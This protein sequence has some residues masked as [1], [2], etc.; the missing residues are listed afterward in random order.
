MACLASIS[1]FDN[2]DYSV[3]DTAYQLK[4]K[5]EGDPV[6]ETIRQDAN[7]FAWQVVMRPYAQWREKHKI[8]AAIAGCE[9]SSN[10]IVKF[11]N[12]ADR[13]AFFAAFPMA[14][15]DESDY[16]ETDYIPVD[17]VAAEKR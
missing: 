14:R 17:Y 15:S 13:A 9:G 2:G 10:V 4:L 16:D 8:R 6:T 5:G 7:K 11:E 12:P 1:I 3:F